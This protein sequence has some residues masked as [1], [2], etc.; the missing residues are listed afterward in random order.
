MCLYSECILKLDFELM[1]F[2]AQSIRLKICTFDATRP[3][4]ANQLCDG[5]STSRSAWGLVELR[6]RVIAKNVGWGKR[7]RAWRIESSS[8]S[9][10]HGDRRYKETKGVRFSVCTLLDSSRWSDVRRHVALDRIA[11]HPPI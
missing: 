7:N 1:E 9:L 10:H 11:R 5:W 4:M 3:S 2:V 6:R 8:P